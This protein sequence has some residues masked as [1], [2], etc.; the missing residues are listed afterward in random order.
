MIDNYPAGAT[1][2]P[3]APYNRKD[4]TYS[5]FESFT[6]VINVDAIPVPT[7]D[8]ECDYDDEPRICN[9]VEHFREQHY[10]PCEI[11]KECMPLVQEKLKKADD[12]DCRK[13]RDVLS[14][15]MVYSQADSRGKFIN[16]S[17]EHV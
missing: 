5:F 17:I 9:P 16:E 14:D 8:Y 2:D 13:W 1:N 3:R 11:I 12:K 7:D 15:M 10:T 4:G 6:I